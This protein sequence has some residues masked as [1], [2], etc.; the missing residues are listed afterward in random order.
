MSGTEVSGLQPARHGNP[1][2]S[3]SSYVFFDDCADVENDAASETNNINTNA[4]ADR[5]LRRRADKVL[6]RN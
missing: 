1:R 4:V 2:F 3:F 5:K 6:W